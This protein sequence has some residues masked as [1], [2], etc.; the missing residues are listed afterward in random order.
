MRFRQKR[1]K[2]LRFSALVLLHE[3]HEA[4]DFETKTQ[5]KITAAETR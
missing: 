1:R 2:A 5:D 3:R 4:G